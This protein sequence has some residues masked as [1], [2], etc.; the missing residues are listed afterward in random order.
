MGDYDTIILED[1]P[2]LEFEKV[3]RGE[4]FI[5]DHLLELEL[6]YPEFSHAQYRLIK[7]LYESGKRFLQI[8]PYLEELVRIQFFLAEE[9]HTPG[10]IPIDSTMYSVYDTERQATGKLIDYYEAVQSGDF[11]GI[12]TTMN[13]FAR[14]DAARFVLRD[15]L[16]AE[17]ILAKLNGEGSTYVEAG[18]MHLL[19]YKLIKNDLPEDWSLSSKSIDRLILKHLGLQGKLLSPGD[20]LTLH[21]I[22]DK[23]IPK[24]EWQQL[25]A[26]SVIYTKIISKVELKGKDGQYPHTIDEL[27]AITLVSQLSYFSCKELYY[28]IQSLPTQAAAEIV[29]TYCRKK[30]LLVN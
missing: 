30:A 13:D 26:Q 9:E 14:A 22:F 7:E 19:L 4:I 27:K 10:D 15:T 8:E 12:L 24:K 25:C 5:E 1:P 28:R 21:Y 3:L 18:S 20:T 2:H 11:E 17:Q 16:R 6:G 29:E 23:K